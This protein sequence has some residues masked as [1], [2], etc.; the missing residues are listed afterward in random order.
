MNTCFNGI[1]LCGK[2][3]SVKAYR[4]KNIVSLKPSFS[5]NDLKTRISLYVSDVHTC[6]RRIRELDKSVKFGLIRI[7]NG[8]EN[9]LVIPF[10]LPFFFCLSKIII[11]N[12]T[13][14]SDVIFIQL[15][16]LK[17]QLLLRPARVFQG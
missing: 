17:H 13:S 5:R 1:V 14:V 4:E 6:A 7:V 11:H 16:T 10:F 12:C 15:S 8:I 9:A 3:V 2:S